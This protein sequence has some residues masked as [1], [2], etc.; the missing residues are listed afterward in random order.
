MIMRPTKYDEPTKMFS[1]RV[2][3]SR[4]NEVSDLVKE[5]LSNCKSKEHNALGNKTKPKWMLDAE[6]RIRRKP[7]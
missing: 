1:I 3:E 6:E 7:E 5:F 2:P 4:F